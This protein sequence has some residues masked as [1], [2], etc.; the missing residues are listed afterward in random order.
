MFLLLGAELSSLFPVSGWITVSL[1]TS[2]RNHNKPTFR[3]GVLSPWLK[4]YVVKD[5]VRNPVISCIYRASLL[6]QVQPAKPA[7]GSAFKHTAV[8][9]TSPNV[10][11]KCV[12]ST[13]CSL[14]Q[15]ESSGISMN[16]TVYEKMVQYLHTMKSAMKRCSFSFSGKSTWHLKHCL[17]INTA[18]TK[19]ARGKTNVY[20]TRTTNKSVTKTG[21]SH[22]YRSRCKC[23][24]VFPTC[25][26][27]AKQKSWQGFHCGRWWVFTHQ[28]VECEQLRVQ[29]LHMSQYNRLKKPCSEYLQTLQPLKARGY[30]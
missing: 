1:T 28:D 24:N 20:K 10:V 27:Y 25:A 30:L 18:T 5:C 14:T 22:L 11:Y 23:E 29:R 13:T 17:H 15:H 21:S 16:D 6:I 3:L 9:Y 7:Q 19:W 12:Q 2:D 4:R 8:L 26:I